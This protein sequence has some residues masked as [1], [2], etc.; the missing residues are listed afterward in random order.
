MGKKTTIVNFVIWKSYDGGKH[1]ERERGLPDFATA[2][3]TA[4]SLRTR[5]P[6]IRFRVDAEVGRG[7]A[8]GAGLGPAREKHRSRRH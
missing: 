3:D 6:M 1:W 2:A 5:H 7:I 4:H 8:P